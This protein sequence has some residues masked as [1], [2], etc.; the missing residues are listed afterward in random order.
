MTIANRRAG[1]ARP[2]MVRCAVY[3]RKSTDEGLVREFNT[4]DAQRE[5]AERLVVAV[6]AVVQFD[7]QVAGRRRLDELEV[8]FN[9]ASFLA[10]ARDRDS[11]Q[12]TQPPARS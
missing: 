7:R 6:H 1:E 11:S 10:S 3:T 12:I 4:L 5:A 8:T 9:S 2:R